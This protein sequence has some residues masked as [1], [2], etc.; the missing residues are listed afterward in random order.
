MRR[1]YV[2]QGDQFIPFTFWV[3][4]GLFPISLVK[5]TEQPEIKTFFQV[6]A[7]FLLHE[8]FA[9]SGSMLQYLFHYG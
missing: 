7:E 3:V 1:K 9:Y 6:R 5:I 2:Q 4:I 8:Q